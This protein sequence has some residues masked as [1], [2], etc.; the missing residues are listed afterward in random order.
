MEPEYI[1]MKGSY[2]S[3]CDVMRASFI[4]TRVSQKFYIILVLS[5]YCT[6]SCGYKHIEMRAKRDCKCQRA[7]L[8]RNKCFMITYFQSDNF[9]T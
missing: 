6:G 5:N 3:E 7:G 9:K 1:N 8:K 4:I 2:L